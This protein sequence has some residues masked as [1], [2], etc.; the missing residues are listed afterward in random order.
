MYQAQESLSIASEVNNTALLPGAGRL[1]DDRELEQVSGGF[2]AYEQSLSTSLA[3]LGGAAGL[4]LSAP[5]LAGAFAV[6]SIAASGIAIF[7]ALTDQ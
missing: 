3:F 5:V 6:G 2:S 7:S 4:A 1:L